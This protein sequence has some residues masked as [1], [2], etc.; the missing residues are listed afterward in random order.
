MGGTYKR[1]KYWWIWYK[2]QHGQRHAESKKWTLKRDAEKELSVREV[3]IANHEFHGRHIEETTFNQIA[4]L[5]IEDYKINKKRS[6]RATENRVTRMKKFFGNGKMKAI[7]VPSRVRQFI[8]DCQAED[9]SNAYINR[10][11]SALKRMYALGH[12]RTPKLVAEVPHISL[13]DENNIRSGFFEHGEYLKLHAELPKYLRLALTISYISGIREGENFTIE[14]EQVNFISGTIR[15]RQVDT[16]NKQPRVFYLTGKYYEE[17][18]RQKE[19]LDT[20]HPECRH[21]IHNEGKPVK[22]FKAAW[23]SACVRAGV[24]GRLFHD[25]RRTAAR[26]MLAAGVPEKQ[27]MQIG[28]WKTRSMFDRYNI[29]NEENLKKAS[30]SVIGYL[31][32]QEAAIERKK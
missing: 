30:D 10:Y 15:L 13:L 12:Q 9:L 24:P 26:N 28:G 16:K 3:Q 27:I 11:L 1:G 18:L 6:T 14:L 5:L 23:K 7:C 17:L 25:L 4:A 2:D 31:A 19:E 29:V 21:L 32:E 22:S 20:Q 8:L